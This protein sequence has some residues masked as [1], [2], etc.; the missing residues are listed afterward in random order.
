VRDHAGPET[1]D[2]ATYRQRHAQYKTDPDL[3]AAHAASPWLVVWDDHELQ[4]NWAGDLPIVPQENFDERRAAAFR[5]FYENMP[6]RRSSAPRGVDLQL[7]RRARWGRLATFHLLDTRQFRDN[8]ACGDGYRDGCGA[9]ASPRR[10]ITGGEQEAWLIDDFERSTARWDLIGQQVFF[11]Q[12]DA[13]SGPL[14]PMNMDA[15][16]GYAA[17]RGRITRGWVDAGV[18]NPIVLTGDVHAHWASDLKLD[19]DDPSSPT[20]GAELVCSSIT[21]S[22][23]GAN[24]ATGSHPW[25]ENNPHLRFYNDLRGYVRATVTA[26]ELTADFRCVRRVSQVG[27]RAFTR[28]SFTVHDQRPGLELTHDNPPAN[29]PRRWSDQAV[30]DA[31]IRAETDRP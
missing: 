8:Q 22:G 7:Y 30:I 31:T 4:N 20:V 27:A 21:S 25:L 12:R 13:D 18:R 17:S 28:A 15:W 14:K 23:D 10:S 19:Y 1:T 24:S 11:A 5:A 2:L 9:A 16:D 29:P 3:Q 26:D 6:L